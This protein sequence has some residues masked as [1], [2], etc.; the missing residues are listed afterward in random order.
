M[1]LTA[2]KNAPVQGGFSVKK[3]CIILL[4]ALLLSGCQ[5]S[6]QTQAPETQPT[7]VAP[8]TQPTE[9]IA[10]ETES[11]WVDSVEE[12]AEAIRAARQG[13]MDQT[14][15]NN[16]LDELSVLYAPAETCPGF[17]LFKAEVNPYSVFYYYVPEE[18]EAL[19][20]DDAEDITVTVHRGSEFTMESVCK[21]AQ[22]TPDA[23]GFAYAPEKSSIY[24]QQDD[25]VVSIHAPESMND[26]DTLRSLCRMERVELGAAAARWELTFYAEDPPR[27]CRIDEADAALLD[28]ILDVEKMEPGG[29]VESPC[30]YLFRAGGDV[31]SFDDSLTYVDAQVNQKYCGRYLSEEE[32]AALK[33]LTEKYAE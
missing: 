2:H 10:V 27:T 30:C 20:I 23:D 31:F 32:T 17:R 5:A 19:Y 1:Q 21:Q 18:N 6:E 25:T 33:A 28:E 26:Y 22:I 9:E 11:F 29:P 12:L 15:R 24:F 7:N 16:R 3:I 13:K 14:A 8:E 4:A